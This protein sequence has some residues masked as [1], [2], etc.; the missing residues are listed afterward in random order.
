MFGEGSGE[1]S[2]K[3]SGW[4]GPYVIEV[5]V[6][7]GSCVV[8]VEVEV[9]VD[10]EVEVDVAVVVVEVVVEDVVEVVVEVVEEDDFGVSEVGVVV[11]G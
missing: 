7:V 9:G 11:V 8:E 3:M 5:V 2:M 10:V 6:V 4:K 1:E